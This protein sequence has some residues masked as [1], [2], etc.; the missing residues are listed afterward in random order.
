MDIIIES[1]PSTPKA[2]L[3]NSALAPYLESYCAHFR[4]GRYATTTSV[5]CVAGLAHFARW[6]TQCGL[7]AEQLCPSGKPA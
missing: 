3:L 1:L 2:W 6:M 5:S 7:A 4:L